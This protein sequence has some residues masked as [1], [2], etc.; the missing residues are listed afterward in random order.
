[1]CGLVGFLLGLCIA[2]MTRDFEE[3]NNY[4]TQSTVP[5]EHTLQVGKFLLAKLYHNYNLFKTLILVRIKEI[6]F[7][8]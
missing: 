4:K 6:Y 5:K 1:M 3:R 7:S 2:K 8:Q